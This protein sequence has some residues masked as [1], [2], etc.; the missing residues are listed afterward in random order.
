MLLARVFCVNCLD[1]I[2]VGYI[3]Y[4]VGALVCGVAYRIFGALGWLVA[5]AKFLVGMIPF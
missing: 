1:F 5:Y 4:S 3:Y 2:F